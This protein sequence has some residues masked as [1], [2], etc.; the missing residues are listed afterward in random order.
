ML[1]E[2]GVLGEFLK[3]KAPEDDKV[4]KRD[5]K[6]DT[7]ALQLI[8]EESLLKEKMRHLVQRFLFFTHDDVKR[9]KNPKPDTKLSKKGS[10]PKHSS[11]PH[12][13][14]EELKVDPKP[15]S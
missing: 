11:Q 1:F 2:D 8:N 10:E 12:P 14:H 6:I 13:K 5:D 15:K 3:I 7:L 9:T 4:W